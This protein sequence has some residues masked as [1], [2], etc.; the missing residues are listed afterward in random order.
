[1]GKRILVIGGGQQNNHDIVEA[2]R[3][4]RFHC[5]RAPT[6]ERGLEQLRDRPPDL[7]VVETSLPDMPPHKV[8]ARVRAMAR[9]PLVVTGLSRKTP[10]DRQEVLACLREGADLYIRSREDPDLFVEQVRAQLRKAKQ[11]SQVMISEERV[12]Y[13]NLTIDASAHTV[14]VKGHPVKLTPKEFDLLWILATHEGQAMEAGDLLHEVWGYP[15]DCRTRTLGVHI[16]R[17]RRKLEADP[18]N[19]RMILTVPCIGYMFRSPE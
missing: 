9:V 14:Y 1:M 8:C 16:S 17:L 18:E 4:A 3:T 6:G 5:T 10:K 13:G 15:K 2:L 11:H 12:T 19:P 7:V